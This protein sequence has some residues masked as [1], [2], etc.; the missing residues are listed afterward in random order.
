MP[1]N[2]TSPDSSF[3]PEEPLHPQGAEF[4]EHVT[5]ML[6]G[7]PEDPAAAEAGLSDGDEFLEKIAAELY[8][9]ASMMVGDGEEA[10][11]LIERV[12][13]SV[14]LPSCC[15]HAEAKHKGRLLLAAEAISVLRQRDPSALAAPADDSGP[16]SCIED[17]DLSAAGVTADELEQMIGGPE[18]NRLRDWLEGLP[19]SLRVIFVLRAV[20]GLTSAEVSDLLAENGGSATSDQDASSAWTP[21][22]VRG[23]FRQAL[24][25]LASQLLHASSAR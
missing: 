11:G 25:S 13:A 2:P 3:L 12:V 14:D 7:Q 6:D 22:A 1:A 5:K 19:V 21:A 24:C 4:F 18:G 20:A 17:D 10:I 16:V 8:H 23:G 9:I 15:D